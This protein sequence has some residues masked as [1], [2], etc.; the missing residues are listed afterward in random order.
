MNQELMQELREQLIDAT[1]TFA[2][3][4]ELAF[5]PMFGGACVYAQG[6]VFAILSD[7][8]MALK[9]APETQTGLLQQKGTKRLQFNDDAPIMKQYLVVP[10]TIRNHDRNLAAWAKESVDFALSQPPPKARRK[11][12]V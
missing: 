1:E 4:M 5:R 12:S 6:K 9:F 2:P 8:G 11:K 3:D 10:L 7:V